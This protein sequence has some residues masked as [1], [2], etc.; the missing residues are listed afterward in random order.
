MHGYLLLLFIDLHFLIQWLHEDELY[1]V[2]PYKDMVM[3]PKDC[4]I[5]SIPQGTVCKA[6]Y[7]EELFEVAVV[8]S[9]ECG[10]QIM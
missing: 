9:G 1:D 7:E 6:K 8:S 2:L 5:Y 4:E 10:W 3:L